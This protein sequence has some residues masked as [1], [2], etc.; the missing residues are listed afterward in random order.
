[1][2]GGRK[3]GS[4]R[5]RPRRVEDAV[6]P[7]CRLAVSPTVMKLNEVAEC[8]GNRWSPAGRRK[9]SNK[10]K[11]LQVIDRAQ[12]TQCWL[13]QSIT[14]FLSGRSPLIGLI[15]GPHL[16]PDR[17]FSPCVIALKGK[18]TFLCRL[19]GFFN[20]GEIWEQQKRPAF[21]FF[22]GAAPGCCRRV[23][24]GDQWFHYS[25]CTA[26]AARQGDEGAEAVMAK[27]RFCL[28]KYLNSMLN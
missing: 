4:K 23:R 13:S 5:R 6:C 27:C 2:D 25:Y 9:G 26:P 20:N 16:W 8:P 3:G 19:M 24:L 15:S 18:V 22:N 17:G 7:P 11:G 28:S 21:S 1:M 14:P 12:E 10:E